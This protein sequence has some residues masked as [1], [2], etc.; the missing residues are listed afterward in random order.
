MFKFKV[1]GRRLIDLFKD[2]FKNLEN[3]MV[4]NLERTQ[5]SEGDEM[6]RELRQY[7]GAVKYPIR[8]ASER[9]RRAFFATNGFGRGIPTQRTNALKDGW[10]LVMNAYGDTARLMVLNTQDHEIYV[11][12]LRRQPFHEITGWQDSNEIINRHGALMLNRLDELLGNAL[13]VQ[14]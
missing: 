6:L 8:W 1:V 2:A 4:M 13:E 9:Q 7:P 10:K 3:F 14:D 12:G 5:F 11:T